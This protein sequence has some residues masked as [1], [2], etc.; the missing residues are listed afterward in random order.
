LP[1]LAIADMLRPARAM[2]R[3]YA[4]PAERFHYFFIAMLPPDAE[5]FFT[6]P[7]LRRATP[8]FAIRL[9]GAAASDSVP[10]RAALRRYAI[11]R[12]CL[13]RQRADFRR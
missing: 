7:D 10:L 1:P 11:C 9:H 12:H 3:C 8:I 4:R 2:P 6:P 13:L 5:P